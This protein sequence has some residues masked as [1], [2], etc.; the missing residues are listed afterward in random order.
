MNSFGRANAS[1]RTR[2]GPG[3]VRGHFEIRAL[4][5]RRSCRRCLS[6][7]FFATAAAFPLSLSWLSLLALTSLSSALGTLTLS[8]GNTALVLHIPRSGFTWLVLEPTTLTP[9]ARL[10]TSL[11]VRFLHLG[12]TTA[13]TFATSGLR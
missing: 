4:L 5:L 8:L 12:S 2:K 1:L 13:T 11:G 6:L 9:A 3:R 7:G 10:C